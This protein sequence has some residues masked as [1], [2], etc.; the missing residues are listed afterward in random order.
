MRRIARALKLRKRM[1]EPSRHHAI[2]DGLIHVDI[3]FLTFVS[4][5]TVSSRDAFFHASDYARE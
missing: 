4:S 3:S 1:H 2:E 5:A